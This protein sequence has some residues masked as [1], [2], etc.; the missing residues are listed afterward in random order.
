MTIHKFTLQ[1]KGLQTVIMPK[2]SVIL[3][4]QEQGGTVRLWALVD[5]K[6]P[7][8]ERTFGVFGTGEPIPNGAW[9]FV[10]T[11][12]QM[13]GLLVWHVLEARKP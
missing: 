13:G 6:Q 7:D 2:G 5:P 12:Q 9:A 4:A 3:S 11:V 10:G 8:E 1:A